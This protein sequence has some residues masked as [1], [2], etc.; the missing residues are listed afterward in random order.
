MIGGPDWRE[1]DTAVTEDR[2]RDTE[3]HGRPE[4]LVPADLAVVMGMQVDEPGGYDRAV[5]ID[6]TIGRR[7]AVADL[8]DFAV[9]DADR[10]LVR[11]AAIAVVH[12]TTGDLEVEYH[13]L[14]ATRCGHPG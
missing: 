5:R 9:A 6:Y 8:G 1:T 4:L 2:C 7:F 13:C 10:C 11:L 12:Q 3:V 14:S